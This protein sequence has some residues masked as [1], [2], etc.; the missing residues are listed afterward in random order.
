VIDDQS[1]RVIASVHAD[2][3]TLLSIK[4]GIPVTLAEIRANPQAAR[5]AALSGTV[6]IPHVPAVTLMGVLGTSQITGGTLDG[7]I[8]LG[9]T[10]TTPTVDAKLV[11]REVRGPPGGGTPALAEQHPTPRPTRGC[12]PG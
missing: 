10:V 12:K 6:T 8:K 4:A 1:S 5:A 9:G 7:T 2:N 11:A 3:I